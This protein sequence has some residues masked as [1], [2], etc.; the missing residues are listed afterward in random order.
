MGI[1]NELFQRTSGDEAADLPSNVAYAMMN[2]MT[3]RIDHS[4]RIVL[5]KPLR[6]RFGLQDG[7]DLEISESENGILL[8]PVRQRPSLVREGVFLIHEGVPATGMSH[9]IA[10]D[11]EARM[12]HLLGQ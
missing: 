7:A 11:R 10:E 6:D 3:L 8:T 1:R 2:G 9:A 5:P 4:G 12:K